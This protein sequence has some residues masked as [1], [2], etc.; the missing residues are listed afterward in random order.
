MINLSKFRLPYRE[1]STFSC[2]SFLVFIVPLAFF[3][4][5]NE[6]YE[7]AKFSC[8]LVLTGCASACFLARQPKNKIEWKFNRP[9]F[10]LLAAFFVWAALATAFSA[11]VPYSVFGFYYRFTDGLIFYSALI[12][13][14]FLLA[15]TLDKGRLV[16]LFKI[17]VFDAL[18]VAVVSCLQAFNI[19]YYAGAAAGLVQGPSL[20]GNPD[21]SAMFLS[22]AI[23]FVLIFWVLAKSFASKIYYGLCFFVILTAGFILASRGAL[24]AI[25]A[26]VCAGL[27]LLLAYHFPK[28]YFF[29][30]LFLC[31]AGFGYGKIFL[32]VSRPTAVSTIIGSVDANTTSRLAAWQITL[33][34][35]ARHPVFGNGPGTFAMF[36]E[37]NM[38]TAPRIGVFDD[39][40][41]LFLRLAAT[42][43]LPFL[44]I[45]LGML[46]TACYYG[47]KKLKTEKDLITL[48]C[49]A[50]LMAWCIGVSF[51]P[52]TITMFIFLAVL[53][54]GLLID[55]TKSSE[56]SLKIRPKLIVYVLAAI[57]IIFGV[58]LA[59]SEYFFGFAKRDYLNQDYAQAYRLSV[60]A[61]K[62]NPSNGVY[63]LYRIGSEIGLNKNPADII[64]D[65]N[66]LTAKSRGQ[67]GIYVQA[68]NLY[69][70]LY[71]ST[72]NKDYLKFAISEMDRSLEIDP[73]FADRYG[74]ESVYYY[75]LGNLG[76]SKA[77]VIKNLNLDSGNFAPWVLLAK[78]YQL[79]GNKQGVVYSLTRAFKLRPDIPQ[80]GYYLYLA[81]N[82]SDIKKLPLQIAP[83]PPHLE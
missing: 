15:Q 76:A 8:L 74:Q 14:L 46:G 79:E 2:L 1:D 61:E 49:L 51:N 65:I 16:F 39:P 19:T 17:L 25:L 6:G 21:F 33:T 54:S 83:M 47:G 66:S 32:D 57:L 20:L 40:H 13:F 3:L 62:I 38:A 48:A 56:V 27:V 70:L 23:P 22:V 73:F 45:F 26:S 35:I 82:G 67:A 59:A 60:L 75:E 64:K 55:Y 53:L 5:T 81:K 4:L 31:L 7:T 72:G 68:S 43:G 63:E 18:V 77:A 28:K 41:N 29:G 44:F 12:I 24:L 69:D 50:A 42:C 34:G 11:N 10:Y 78:I 9:F 58:D 71:S 80:L 36:F 52:A 37:R 30:L